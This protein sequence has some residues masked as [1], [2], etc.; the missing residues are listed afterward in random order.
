[1]SG[2]TAP[3][4]S[5]SR[6]PRASGV[7]GAR[8]LRRCVEAA[9]TRALGAE[10]AEDEGEAVVLVARELLGPRDRAVLRRDHGPVGVRELGEPALDGRAGMNDCGVGLVVRVLEYP[11]KLVGGDVEDLRRVERLRRCSPEPE[12]GAGGAGRSL[13][14]RSPD[15]EHAGHRAGG[16]VA[17]AEPTS[18]ESSFRALQI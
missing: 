17:G 13:R 3:G 10:D 7:R 15:H 6:G 9:V 8:E 11:V 4:P 2:R 18:N 16:I 14:R 5:S 12:C 1:M